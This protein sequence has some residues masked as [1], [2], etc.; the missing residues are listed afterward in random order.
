M[1]LISSFIYNTST[2]LTTRSANTKTVKGGAL[3]ILW[4][5]WWPWVPSEIYA[6]HSKKLFSK[7]TFL[8]R[9]VPIWRGK[10]SGQRNL[11]LLL[12]PNKKCIPSSNF[13]CIYS[14]KRL[15]LKIKRFTVWLPQPKNTDIWQC[16]TLQDLC[17]FVKLYKD[18][19]T[20]LRT[21]GN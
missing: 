3:W 19:K 13:T 7:T 21:I 12:L 15:P 6:A 2:F 20:L 18:K 16:K 10:V 4:R 8:K 14:Q 9:K 1:V 11:E 17:V 5:H